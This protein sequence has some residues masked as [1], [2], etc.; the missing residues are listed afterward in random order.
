MIA[1]LWLSCNSALQSLTACHRR[2][3]GEKRRQLPLATNFGPRRPRQQTRRGRA[4]GRTSRL[5]TNLLLLQHGY[6][7]TALVSH[8]KLIEQ[9]KADYYLALS[10]AQSSWKSSEEDIY[11]WLVYFL[12]IVRSQATGALALMAKDRIENLLSEK[13]LAL[14]QWAQARNAPEFSRKDAIEQAWQTGVSA[15][16]VTVHF[17]DFGMDSGPVIAQEQVPRNPDDTLETLAER[18]H[19]PAHRLLPQVVRALVQQGPLHVWERVRV[20]PELVRNS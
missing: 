9:R 1:L 12:G 6:M 11:P 17:V 16:G 2:S 20:N 5:L 10:Q 3:S 14:W 18:I 15:T 13:Q 4:V 7:F 19:Q 8:E